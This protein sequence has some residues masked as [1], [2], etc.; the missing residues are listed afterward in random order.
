MMG[1]PDCPAFGGK[2]HTDAGTPGVEEGGQKETNHNRGY[3]KWK[4]PL[5]QLVLRHLSE[6][7]YNT[8]ELNWLVRPRSRLAANDTILVSLL[9]NFF[10]RG[11][12]PDS[13][14]KRILYNGQLGLHG[15]NKLIGFY[16]NDKFLSD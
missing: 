8:A 11:S 6:F 5:A 13:E 14:Y 16:V 9:Y 1:V 12:M 15:V 3:T 10:P 4:D 2:T 7:S